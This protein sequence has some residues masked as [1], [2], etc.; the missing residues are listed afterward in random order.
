M[1]RFLAGDGLQPGDVDGIDGLCIEVKNAKTQ[2]MPA[3][4]RQAH[5]EAGDNFAVVVSKPRGVT[6]PA[7]WHATVTFED[8]MT[9]WEKNV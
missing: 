7:L 9:L 3:W 6:D 4:L 2:A 8:F 1:R 5:E